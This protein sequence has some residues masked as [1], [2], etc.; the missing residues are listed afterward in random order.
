MADG[1][2]GVAHMTSVHRRTAPDE[3]H[4]RAYDYADSFEVVLAEPDGH[5]AEEW[6]RTA[7][8]QSHPLVRRLIRVVHARVLCFDLGPSDKQHILGWR[9]VS[10]DPDGLQLEAGGPLGRAVIVARRTS[11][12]ASAVSTYVFFTRQRA[13]LIW[14]VVGPVHRRV[15]PYLLRRAAR[16]LVQEMSGAAE[17]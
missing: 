7:L 6:A 14:A 12:T 16:A 15:A 3:P 2:A 13:R 1:T 4:A 5:S 10:S 9:I 17:H 8:E 11:P